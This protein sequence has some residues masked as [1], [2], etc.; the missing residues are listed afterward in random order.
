MMLT[1]L[2]SGILG[3]TFA[4]CCPPVITNQP[5]SQTVVVGSTVNFSVG[6]SSATSP[7][8]H[9]RFNGVNI[10][11]ATATNYTLF[12]AQPTNAGNYSVAITNAAGTPLSATSP[13]TMPS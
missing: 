10:A 2:H 13:M 8:Y 1:V 11:G 7:N 4:Q 9:W 3:V 5:Q 6:V 12:D